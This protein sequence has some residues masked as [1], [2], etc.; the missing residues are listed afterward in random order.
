MPTSQN[1]WSAAPDLRIRPLIVAGESFSPGVRDDD[2]V[3]EVLRYVAEQMHARVEP[4][5]RDDWHQADDWGFYYRPNAND[6]NSLSNHSSATAIDYNATRHPNGVATSATFTP[7]QIAEIHKI[8]AECDGAVRWGGDY[9][10]TADAM[11]FEINTNATHLR[12]V[13][14]RLREGDHDMPSPEETR[15]IV[16]EEIAAALSDI[17][18]E[19]VVNPGDQGPGSRSLA[20]MLWAQLRAQRVTNDLLRDLVK[21]NRDASKR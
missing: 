15:A 19:R 3:F 9:T 20:S 2:D 7:A 16:R 14:D 11:H 21:A 6:P 13:A 12:A 8:L 18:D 10:R 1:G 17:G 5:V 4:I